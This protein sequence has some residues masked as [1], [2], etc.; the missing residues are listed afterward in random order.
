MTVQSYKQLVAWQRAMELVVAVYALEFPRHE[1][2]GL[3]SQIRRS[4]VSVASNIAE[5]QGRYSTNDFLRHLSI[6]YGS[7]MELETQ[8]MIAR[9]LDY[10][11][12]ETETAVLSIAGETGRLVNGLS[13]SL[14]ARVLLTNE[15]KI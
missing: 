14:R 2:Y 7:L 3:T 10:I 11:S 15:N 12:Q 6:A 9:R 1:L 5:G 13:K 8:L 4:A